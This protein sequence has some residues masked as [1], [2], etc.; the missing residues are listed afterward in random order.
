MQPLVQPLSP[1]C[2]EGRD[3]ATVSV[4]C[5]LDQSFIFTLE[6]KPGSLVARVPSLP[7]PSHHLWLQIRSDW[8]QWVLLDIM[9]GGGRQG[10]ERNYGVGGH[11]R[12]NM[13]PLST[14]MQ[15]HA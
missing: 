9:E 8:G 5:S 4:G 14:H 12:K 1:C 2:W 15:T 6:G 11:R 7:C 13:V 10:A 3:Q